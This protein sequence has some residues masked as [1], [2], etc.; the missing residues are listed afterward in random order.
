VKPL[1]LLIILAGIPGNAAD[2]PMTRH[3]D[4][5]PVEQAFCFLNMKTDTVP[6]LKPYWNTPA[7]SFDRSQCMLTSVMNP[8]KWGI[9]TNRNKIYILWSGAIIYFTNHRVI[10]TKP[11]VIVDNGHSYKAV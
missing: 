10:T 1:E 11:I 6:H 4:N 2:F 5:K 9:C 7:R 3:F 8:Y